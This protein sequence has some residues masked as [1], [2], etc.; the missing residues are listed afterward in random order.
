MNELRVIEN[1]TSIINKSGIKIFSNDE[2]GLQVR[3]IM[4]DDGSISISAE[5]TA[6]GFGWTQEKNGKIYPKWER[7]N[8]YCNEMGFSPQVGKGD[9]IPEPLFYRLGMKANNE[10]AEKY[11]NWLAFDV[12]PELRK[13][14]SYSL[15][16]EQ[17]TPQPDT[18]T[19][20][21]RIKMMELI[22]TCPPEALEYVAGMAKP[23]MAADRKPPVCTK[24][25]LAQV[26][27]AA[28]TTPFRDI[29]EDIFGHSAHS[30]Q[31]PVPAPATIAEPAKEK[32]STSGYMEPFNL[33]KLSN[34]LKRTGVTRSELA[35]RSGIDHSQIG[36]YLRGVNRPGRDSRDKMCI[37]LG[38]PSAW[39][40][41]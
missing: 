11:Q 35:K 26:A 2:L 30:V 25:A 27:T 16:C 38:K 1:E 33:S 22:A 12:L 41:M 36:R 40:D 8:G 32:M 17:P 13:T 7:M 21:D 9:Y 34:H 37:A 28:S 18:L 6:I 4:N 10:T 20:A 39:L 19:T 31:V 14:G 15:Q 29:F 23:F 3:A 5:D 24:L